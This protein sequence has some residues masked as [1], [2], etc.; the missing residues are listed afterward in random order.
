MHRNIHGLLF[1]LVFCSNIFAAS[2]PS[3]LNLN[4]LKLEDLA[5]L[6]ITEVSKRHEKI[7]QTPAAVS[8]LSSQDILDTGVLQLVE[9]LRYIPGIEVA[10]I[11]SGQWAV[12]IRGFNERTANKLLVMVDGRSIYSTLFSGILWEE[13]NILVED[14]QQIEVIRGPGGALWGANAMNGV[15]NI[16][17]KSA[18]D[19]QST[20]VRTSV[21]NQTKH[22]SVARHGW[23]DNRQASRI[24]AGYETYDGVMVDQ[25]KDEGSKK[26]VGFRSD[27]NLE[28]DD[29]I[30]ISGASYKGWQ[31]NQDYASNRLG[32][33]Y[34]GYNLDIKYKQTLNEERSRTWFAFI[35]Q[36]SLKSNLVLDRRTNAFISLEQSEKILQTDL[37]WGF[38]YQQISDQTRGNQFFYFS[39]EKDKHMVYSAFFNDR[40]Q[41]NDYPIQWSFGLKLEKHPDFGLESQPSTSLSWSPEHGFYW[42]KVNRAI[43]VPSRLE[44]DIVA[45]DFNVNSEFDSE[46]AEVI[47]LGYRKLFNQQ[48]SLDL[49][50]YTG[51]Y[52][53]LR[54]IGMESFTN[55]STA[56][57]KGVDIELKWIISPQ[58]KLL[59]FYNYQDIN[60]NYDQNVI[61]FDNPDQVKGSSPEHKFNLQPVWQINTNNRLSLALRYRSKLDFYDLPSKLV[62]DINYQWEIN[63]KVA[64]S[65]AAHNLLEDAHFEWGTSNAH[66]ISPRYS[67]II[68][69]N[70]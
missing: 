12:T 26:Y 10:Q 2:Q 28:S 33:N 37:V 60:L 41:L 40:I 62:A 68:R 8:V 50:A 55:D 16:I 6:T 36:S 39:P 13:K 53:R 56:K 23:G 5:E 70:W 7:Y 29:L 65:F 58:S 31:G 9:L 44:S 25:Q 42:L 43:R 52:T 11:N 17:T 22:Q 30:T 57:N 61:L 38:S 35:D 54:T 63:Q 15:I 34:W 32:Q 4:D 69:A 19:T 14:I 64:L 20:L 3:T 49:T 1:G 66:P 24:Y 47:E 59:F 67:L 45:G 18:F 27:L 46:V 51:H 21:S 48:L